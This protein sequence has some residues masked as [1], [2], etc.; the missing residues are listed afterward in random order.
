MFAQGLNSCHDGQVLFKPK[1]GRLCSYVR[2][3]PMTETGNAVFGTLFV[4]AKFKLASASSPKL[5]D[6]TVNAL[7]LSTNDLQGQHTVGTW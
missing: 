3:V 6:D 4:L 1:Y 5:A 2:E 7:L